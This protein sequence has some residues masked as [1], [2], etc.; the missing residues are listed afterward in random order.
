MDTAESKEKLQDLF[1]KIEASY[2]SATELVFMND[3]Y[4]DVKFFKHKIEIGHVRISIVPVVVQ[5]QFRGLELAQVVDH[6][7]GEEILVSQVPS[8]IVVIACR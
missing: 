5:N 6:Y 2:E 3:Q 4:M 1:N 8:A 7:S